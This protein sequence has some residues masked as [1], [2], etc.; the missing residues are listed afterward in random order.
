MLF[1]VDAVMV[2]STAIHTMLCGCYEALGA[3]KPLITSNQIVLREYFSGAVFVEN[4]TIGISNGIKE[5]L[6]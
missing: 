5:I 2:L 3:E 4:T 1:S 6:K